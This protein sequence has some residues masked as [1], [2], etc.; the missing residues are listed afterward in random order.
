M[1]EMA[2]LANLDGFHGHFNTVAE[3]KAWA[4]SL[5]AQHGLTGKVC[6]I[7]KATWVAKDGSGAS[8]DGVPS[9]QIVVG[10]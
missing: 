10:A 5:H 9:A 7:W 1:D 6:K 2:Y 4:E 3:L 8:Y